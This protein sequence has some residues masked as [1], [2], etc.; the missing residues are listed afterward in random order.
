MF[1]AFIILFSPCLLLVEQSPSPVISFEKPH[2]DFGKI[3]QGA[4][5]S[6]KVGVSNLG[7]GALHITDIKTS[8][9]CSDTTIGRSLLNPGE[10]TSIEIRFDS[11]GMMG[12]VRKSLKVTSNDPSNSVATL[13]FE[14]NI[15][16]DIT[17]S[18][19]VVFFHNVPRDG[20]STS[21]ILLQSGNDEPVSVTGTSIPDAPYLSCETRKDG[22]NTILDVTINGRLIPKQA[23]RGNKT[24]MVTTT[25]VNDPTL[26]FHIQWD[27]EPFIVVVPNR[28]VWKETA[29][30]ELSATVH[31][32]NPSGRAFKVLKV[33]S[34]SPLLKVASIGKDSAVE[35]KLDVTFSSKAKIG[36]YNE[37]LTLVLDDPDQSELEI[38]VV[39][40]LK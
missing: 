26:L 39:A 32:N 28:I 12:H 27:A 31:L 38:D 23:S 8:C 15:M 33:K 19:T 22:I 5:V 11:T 25:S 37:K 35:H 20:T 24:L 16:R 30:K 7:D 36:G 34:S 9:D 29:G 13:T 18:T 10:S 40:A 2:H 3:A 14:A 21:S 17:P 6:H 4:K 1:F